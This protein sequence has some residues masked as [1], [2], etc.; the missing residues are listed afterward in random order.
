MMKYFYHG[1]MKDRNMNVPIVSELFSERSNLA[2]FPV[3]IWPTKTL[4][5][6]SIICN[7]RGLRQENNYI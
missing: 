5:T 7:L 1:V 2:E 3:I 4:I 6:E